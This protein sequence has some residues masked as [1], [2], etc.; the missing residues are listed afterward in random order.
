MTAK[1][2]LTVRAF[3]SG[4]PAMYSDVKVT[5]DVIEESTYS[6]EV[7]SLEVHIS[8]Y[9]D[10]FPG[11]VIGTLKAV[12]GDKFDT[13]D[14]TVVSM[15]RNLFDI[16][17]KDG[18]VI[19]FAGLDSGSYTVNVSV[20]DGKYT[21]YGTVNVVVT[22]ITEEMI[23]NAVTIQFADM[24]AQDFVKLYRK[25]FIK[26]LKNEFN[27]RNED[28][29]IISIQKSESINLSERKRRDTSGSNNLDILFAISKGNEYIPKDRLKR[30]VSKLSDDLE[31]SMGV[32]V[33]KV[34]ADICEKDMCAGGKC[35]GS[36]V[37]DKDSL[38]PVF[39]DGGSFVAAKHRYTYECECP[40]GN[41]GKYG[42]CE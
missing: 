13:L 19:A 20:S 42:Y 36:V 3:D 31:S 35:V 29:S 23:A 9:M 12:D 21:S 41:I 24:T 5:V 18:R 22:T 4:T 26:T 8:S 28:I 6:P 10:D 2:D 34:I 33:V 37:F 16:D 27:V 39:M 40:N 14:Y 30:R 1:Y 11:G 7:S 15:H 32:Q 17:K 38:V 25:D